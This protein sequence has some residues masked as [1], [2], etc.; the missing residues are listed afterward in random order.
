MS[1]PPKIRLRRDTSTNLVANNPILASGEP[2]FAMDTKMLKIGDNSTAWTALPAIIK[3][4]TTGI[5]GAS[6]IYNIVSISSGNYSA[7]GSY[8]PNTIYFVYWNGDI[9]WYMTFIPESTIYIGPQPVVSIAFG[10]VLLKIIKVG[11]TEIADLTN[12]NG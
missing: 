10:E 4:D 2:I 8:D 3:S 12:E 7:L 11:E 9:W 6:G 1:R 5:T